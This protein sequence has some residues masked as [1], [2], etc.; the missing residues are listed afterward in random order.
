MAGAILTTDL[1]PKDGIRRS[2]ATARNGRV[3]GHDQGSGMIQPLMATTLGFVLTD[4]DIP[5]APLRTVLKRG[6]ERS[7]NR[8]SVDG[9]TSTNDTLGCWRMALRACGPTRR[10]CRGEAAMAGVMES[11]HRPSRAMAKARASSSRLVEGAAN[12]EAARRSRAASP[13][14]RW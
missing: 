6:V 10:R 7:Y 11:W 12:E 1:V 3:C 14:R 8:L 9:D 13:I 5:P 2:K 4:A